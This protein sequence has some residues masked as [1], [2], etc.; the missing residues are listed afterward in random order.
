MSLSRHEIAPG[1][2][3]GY[4]DVS[5]YP[6]KIRGFLSQM[7]RLPSLRQLRKVM[8]LAFQALFPA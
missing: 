1:R 4:Q 6:G 8:I 2:L 7:R 5:P 3:F